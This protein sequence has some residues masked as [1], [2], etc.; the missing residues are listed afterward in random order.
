MIVTLLLALNAC[1]GGKPA[2]AASQSPAVDAANAKGERDRSGSN[3]AALDLN[4]KQLK[5][6]HVDAV[7]TQAFPRRREAVG[8]IDFD[9]DVAVQVFTPYPGRIIEA[10]AK[11][12]DDVREGGLLFTVD[13]PDLVQAESNLIAAAAVLDLTSAAL[14]RAKELY[15]REGIAEK[16]L[17]QA[18]SDEQTAQGTLK[19][20]RD[21]VRVFGKSE[22]NI[23]EIIAL[24]KIDPALVVRSPITGRVTA[25]NAQPGLL[26]Q[27]GN[28]PAPYSVAD[29]SHMWMLAEVAETDSPLYRKGQEVHVKV[30]AFPDRDFE[31]K[32][33]NIGATVDPN[34]HTI[35]VRSDVADPKHELRPGMFATYVINVDSPMNALGIPLNGV[36]REGDGTMTVWV[37]TDTHHFV[38]RTVRIGLQENGYDQIVDGLAPGERVVTDGAVFLSNMVNAAAVS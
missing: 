5:S 2:V 23:D 18:V 38:R 11:V 16:D 28:T 3:E 10:H 17:Q 34:T 15:G 36:V 22:P 7:S 25:R 32:I 31:G 8:S 14:N 24:R 30:A 29:L 27:P 12:G 4:D 19:A 20:A 1:S 21:A 13:S 6:V 9:E 26:V 33:T 35:L 37:A